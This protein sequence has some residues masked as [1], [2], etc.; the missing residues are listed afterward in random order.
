MRNLPDI[1]GAFILLIDRLWMDFTFIICLNDLENI[2]TRIPVSSVKLPGEV[3]IT[4]IILGLRVALHEARSTL[5]IFWNEFH[6]GALPT[7]K[8]ISLISE[9]GKP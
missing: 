5:I 7:S 2:E 8:L 3:V 6:S 4:E 9:R 1:G